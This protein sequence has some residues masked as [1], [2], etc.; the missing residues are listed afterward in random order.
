MGDR[1]EEIKARLEAASAEASAEAP[2]PPRGGLHSWVISAAHAPDD[3]EYLLGQLEPL[4][5]RCERQMEQ[6][7]CAERV[8]TAARRAYEFLVQEDYRAA[9]VGDLRDALAAEA[10]EASDG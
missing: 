8:E 6:L 3:I 9:V 10:G 2:G 7:Q 5:Q 4:R 1:I